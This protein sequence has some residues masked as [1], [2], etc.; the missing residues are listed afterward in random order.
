MQAVEFSEEELGLSSTMQGVDA[1]DL[2]EKAKEVAE[3][4]KRDAGERRRGLLSV[5]DDVHPLSAPVSAGLIGP[6]L[7][8]FPDAEFNVQA[9][10]KFFKRCTWIAVEGASVS[11]LNKI[12]PPG[13]VSEK[14]R[15]VAFPKEVM[16]A[17]KEH[18]TLGDVDGLYF[19]VTSMDFKENIVCMDFK[20]KI[21]ACT[22]SLYRFGGG[23]VL[24]PHIIEVIYD[25]R[26]KIMEAAGAD[27]DAWSKSLS[28]ALSSGN[29]AMVYV[30]LYYFIT[31]VF[32]KIGMHA[33]AF[34]DGEAALKL[35]K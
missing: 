11:D 7:K 21:Y 6:I 10:K 17:V 9:A 14:A 29:P 35:F 31:H 28:A 13:V 22:C 5:V 16:E 33:A 4:L 18:L 24:C 27:A 32:A 25:L 23:R 15:R 12:M 1:G 19:R 30:W 20:E 8:R 3:S 2:L 26:R 34:E